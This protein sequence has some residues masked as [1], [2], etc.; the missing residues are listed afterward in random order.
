MPEAQLAGQVIAI[1]AG[2]DPDI[3]DRFIFSII[4]GGDDFLIDDQGWLQIARSFNFEV[5][6][7]S[8]I[9]IVCIIDFGG[10]TFD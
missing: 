1:L 2:Q 5:D 10:L 3:G 4:S 7:A 6:G 8:R 9:V